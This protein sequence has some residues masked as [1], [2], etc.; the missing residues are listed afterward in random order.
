[1]IKRIIYTT[2]IFI[3]L[4]SFSSCNDESLDSWQDDKELNLE[5][6]I[7]V[8]FDI[9]GPEDT[10]TRSVESQKPKFNEGDVIH[11][12]ATFYNN[13][14]ASATSYAAMKLMGRSWTF[15]DGTELLWPYDAD[16]GEFRA[17]YLPQLNGALRKGTHSDKVLLS[18]LEKTES[19]ADYDQDPLKAIT[20]RYE[21]GHA[22]ELHFT[23]A[24][25]Y[26]TFINL[27]PGVSDYFWLV[28]KNDNNATNGEGSLKGLNNAF[29]LELTSDNKLDIKFFKDEE[30]AYGEETYVAGKSIIYPNEGGSGSYVSRVMVS[31]FLEPGDYRNIELRTSTNH[32]YLALVSDE[33]SNLEAHRPYVIDAVKSNGLTYT[34][35]DDEAW[36]EEGEY[37]VVVKDFIEAAVIG[38]DYSVDDGTGNNVGILEAISNGV[39]LL[40]NVKFPDNQEDYDDIWGKD[41]DFTPNIP[42]GRVFEGDHHYISNLKQPLFQYNAGTIQNLGLKNVDCDVESKYLGN[43]DNNDYKYDRSRRG[44]LC[45]WNRAGGLIS[46]IRIESLELNIKVTGGDQI[47]KHYA[48]G[49]CGSNEGS[50]TDI[51]FKGDFFVSVDNADNT[52]VVDSEVMIGGITGENVGSIYRV[53]PIDGSGSEEKIKVTN[54]CRGDGGVFSMGGAVGYNTGVIENIS[55]PAVEVDGSLSDGYQQYTGGLV[56]RLRGGQ[57]TNLVFSCTVGGS[58]R[59]GHISSYGTEMQDSYMYTGGLAGSCMVFTV[60]DCATTC[61]VDGNP[62]SDGTNNTSGLENNSRY[63]TGGVFGIILADSGEDRNNISNITGWNTGISGPANTTNE[64]ESYFGTFSGLAPAD[65]LWKDYSSAGVTVKSQSGID[66]EIGAS[67]NFTN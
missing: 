45:L 2:F 42:S 16:F 25:T 33:T 63:A 21:Y 27:D 26:L 58:V 47:H 54:N 11:I 67:K 40:Q 4:F 56:G 66:S 37:V 34:L 36:S 53:S 44:A 31:F 5:G 60:T 43:A 62:S 55:L 50:I 13:S 61:S 15:T 28:N 48:G 10:L 14:G 9:F 19:K 22:V 3:F 41:S 17:F 24:C 51:S 29:Y 35:E 1:M 7:P 46:N 59:V 64:Y 20:F 12:E 39:I 30:N 8:L 52:K 32:P 18:N 57:S 49:V 65:K 23:H 38:K 6:E